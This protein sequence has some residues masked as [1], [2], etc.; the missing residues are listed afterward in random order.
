MVHS[1]TSL[2]NKICGEDMTC[3]LLAVMSLEGMI[4]CSPVCES[5]HVRRD[6]C[7]RMTVLKSRC[8]Y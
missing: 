5:R 4:D 1:G 8:A 3:E 6:T 2:N 7:L